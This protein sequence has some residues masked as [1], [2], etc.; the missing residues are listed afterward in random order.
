MTASCEFQADAGGHPQ[1]PWPHLRS[2][3]AAV[4]SRPSAPSS[5]LQEQDEHPLDRTLTTTFT[6]SDSLAAPV[7]RS[8]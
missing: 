2:P 1:H 6:S 5:Y 3:V 7:G 8:R 4:P